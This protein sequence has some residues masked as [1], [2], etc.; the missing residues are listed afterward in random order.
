[1]N[2]PLRLAGMLAVSVSLIAVATSANAGSFALREQSTRGLGLSFAG[3]AA[4]SGGLTSTYW[5]P[6]TI[7]MNPGLTFESAVTMVSPRSTIKPDAR[8]LATVRGAGGVPTGSGN[9]SQTGVLPTSAGSLQITDNLWL[10][11]TTNTPY[12]FITKPHQNWAGQI[13]GRTS[14][15][16]T[17]NAT[18][19][20]GVKVNEWLSLGA[21]LQIQYMDVTL[22]QASGV[23]FGAMNVNLQGNDTG[24]G[25]TVGATITPMNGTVIGIGFR[26]GIHHELDGT[27]E[28]PRPPLPLPIS[29]PVRAKVNTPEVL[30]VGVSQTVNE[31]W[32]VLGGFEWTNWSRLS[33]VAVTNQITG[34]PQ[35]ALKFNYKDG[36]FASLGAEYAMSKDLVFRGGLGYEWSP[37]SDSVR[38]VRIPD[39]NRVWASL[40]AS[41]QWNDKLAFD[42]SYAHLF[43]KS[44]PI[45][46]VPGHPDYIGLP[47]VASLKP[48]ADIVSLGM[49]YTWDDPKKP[50]AMFQ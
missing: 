29:I 20:V 35:T 7:T 5:N 6:A 34:Q 50:I 32:K 21:G 15:V 17:I 10:G 42:I 49:R 13:Y 9:I 19:M 14:K 16:M 22:R 43:V 24:V 47:F 26:S 25:Y 36:W 37:I 12:G 30:T 41:Y 48:S 3:V 27:I 31:Q 28:T 23:S 4:G 2:T 1:M 39:A 40:G 38:N 46:I 44:A 11:L 8:T 18:P 45:R 33:R